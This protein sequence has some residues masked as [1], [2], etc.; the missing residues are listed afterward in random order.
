MF[1]CP[2]QIDHILLNLKP[3]QAKVHVG[4]SSYMVIRT[5]TT[6]D[7]SCANF[8]LTEVQSLQLLPFIFESLHPYLVIE[9]SKYF[10][11]IVA[12]VAAKK[13]KPCIFYN[14]HTMYIIISLLDLQNITFHPFR[15]RLHTTFS[16]LIVFPKTNNTGTST[17]KLFE[18]QLLQAKHCYCFR[19]MVFFPHLLCGLFSFLDSNFLHFLEATLLQFLMSNSH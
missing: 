19:I 4:F 11:P 1:Q 5:D 3:L 10:W 8:S 16:S 6:F 18:H 14:C 17:A 12:C 2:H 13:C 7:A 15:F 9:P